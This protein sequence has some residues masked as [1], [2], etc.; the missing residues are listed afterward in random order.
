MRFYTIPSLTVQIV[1]PPVLVTMENVPFTPLTLQV[2][3]KKETNNDTGCNGT[4]LGH[5]DPYSHMAAVRT[6]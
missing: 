5:E 2:C 4:N 6:V 3:H 1:G